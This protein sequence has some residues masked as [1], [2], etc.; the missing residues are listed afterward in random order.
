MSWLA[1]LTPSC[2]GQVSLG[3]HLLVVSFVVNYSL[4]PCPCVDGNPL[5]LG[6]VAEDKPSEFSCMYLLYNI[7]YGIVYRGSRSLQNLVAISQGYC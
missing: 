7:M 6:L 3:S 4:V 5:G 1:S 2:C